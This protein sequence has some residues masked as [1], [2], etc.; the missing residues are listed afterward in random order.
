MIDPEDFCDF[1]E[2]LIL[3]HDLIPR[4]SEDHPLHDTSEECVLRTIID[5]SYYAALLKAK[6][7]LEVEDGET[8][9]RVNSHKDV[10]DKIKKSPTVTNGFSIASKLYDLRK[11]R[12]NASYTMNNNFTLS[13]AKSMVNKSKRT[14]KML[15]SH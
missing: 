13:E 12:N 9:S 1:A 11:L 14:I 6:Y 15:Q 5:R 10:M 8:I 4:Y 7:W 2:K 3:F